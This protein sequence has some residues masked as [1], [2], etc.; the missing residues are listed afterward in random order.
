MA[1]NKRYTVAIIG[2]GERGRIHIYGFLKNP[3]KFD[4]VGVYDTDIR[5]VLAQTPNKYGISKEKRFT[6]AEGLMLS[7]AKRFSR[8]FGNH[9][10]LGE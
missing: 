10:N 9:L 5:I 3:D 2:M 1:V 6:D 8:K 4:I 7:C